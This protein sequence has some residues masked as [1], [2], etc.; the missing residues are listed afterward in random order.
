HRNLAGVDFQNGLAPLQVRVAD[1]H[2]AI[3]SP[4]TQQGGVQN[5]LAVGGSDDDD[6]LVGFEAVHFD[7]ELI[8][9]LFALFVAQRVAASA[10]A[11]SMTP[12]REGG[13]GA[14]GKS[15]RTREAPTP[16][17]ISTKPDPVAKRNGTP[18]SPAIE[19]ARRVFPVPG[20]PT[21]STPFGIRPPMAAKRSG[22]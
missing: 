9:G 19:R 12:K 7:E 11:R 5:I 20:G 21:R 1:R 16:A 8:E 10:P 17:Y 22:S 6:A 3:E 15:R 14:S 18:A 4:G 13:R 2:L